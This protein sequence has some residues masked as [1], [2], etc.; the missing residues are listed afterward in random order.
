MLAT[1]AATRLTVGMQRYVQSMP[2]LPDVYADDPTIRVL[3][4]E[5]ARLLGKEA[6]LFVP[7]GC[8]GNEIAV[9]V[10]TRRGMVLTESRAVTELMGRGFQFLESGDRGRLRGADVASVLEGGPD[11]PRLLEAENTFNWH[12]G[13]VYSL[14]ALRGLG[15]AAGRLGIRFHLDGARLWNASA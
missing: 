6:A 14:E 1:R 13:S 10:H 2:A 8:M 3:E 7:S 4:E 5:T 11:P 15:D 9:A 12:S